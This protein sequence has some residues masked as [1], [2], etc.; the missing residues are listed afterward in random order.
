MASPARDARLQAAADGFTEIVERYGGGTKFHNPTTGVYRVV[1]QFQDRGWHLQSDGITEIDSDWVDADPILDAPWLKKMVM[2]DF[3]AFFGPGTDELDAGQI[4]RYVHESG[5][6]LTF[7]LQ[8][9]QWTND[10]DQIQA[11]ADPATISPAPI[12]GEDIVYNNGFGPGIDFVWSTT[13]TQL[14]KRLRIGALS[15]LPTPEAYIL[16]QPNPALKL[17]FI[18]QVATGVQVWVKTIGSPNYVQWNKSARVETAEP[19]E[20]RNNDGSH[21]FWFA[22]PWVS[23][24]IAIDPETGEIVTPDIPTPIMLLDKQGPNLIVQVRVPWSYL[25]DPLVYPVEIDPTASDQV[26]ASNEDATELDDS[27]GF[28][29]VAA[30][31]RTTKSNNAAVRANGGYI[32]TCNIPQGAAIVS[33]S[34]DTYINDATYDDAEM[35]ISLEDV[36]AASNFTVSATVTGR[37]A[38]RTTATTAWNAASLGTGW[39]TCPDIAGSVAEVVARGGFSSG[40]AICVLFEGDVGAPNA[41]YIPLSYDSSSTFA[42]KFTADYTLGNPWYYYANAH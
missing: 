35:I 32:F 24:Q 40:N 5:R 37:I 36:D 28:S 21:L 9:L 19:I 39:Q 26:G 42:A 8:Q 22:K 34:V 30:G 17:Q 2:N 6:D 33:S 11:I 10:L 13:V 7:Q 23:G 3:Q 1:S 29:S 38:S 31:V 25:S 15:D 4:V 20:F 16:A 27:T 41:F 14:I 12:V 18:F